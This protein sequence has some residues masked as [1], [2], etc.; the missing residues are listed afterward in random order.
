MTSTKI[1]DWWHFVCINH[2]I[3][4]FHLHTLTDWDESKQ[5]FQIPNNHLLLNMPWQS[6]NDTKSIEWNVLICIDIVYMQIKF[7]LKWSIV[8]YIFMFVCPLY[9]QQTHLLLQIQCAS[10]NHW[11]GNKS[12]IY[13]SYK[14]KRHQQQLNFAI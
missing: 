7:A 2:L 10:S 3:L 14:K 12:T 9:V 1:V 5:M 4:P 11:S 6:I 8:V 13:K